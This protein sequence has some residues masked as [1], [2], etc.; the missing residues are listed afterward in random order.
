VEG[1]KHGHGKFT[2]ADGSTYEGQFVD[3]NIDG[4]GKT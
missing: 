1:K 3:N 2:W 4:D